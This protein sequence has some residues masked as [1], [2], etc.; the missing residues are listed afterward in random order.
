MFQIVLCTCPN[1]DVANVIAQTLVQEKLAA[2]VNI[3]PKI[4]SVYYWQDKVVCD[5]EIQLLIKTTNEKFALL[6][7]RI[8]SLHTYDVPEIIAVNIQQ[9][10]KQYLN[11]ITE[12]IK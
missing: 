12:S 9:G 10:D 11:W 6:A 7:E 4:T 5:D 1:S 2:C 8:K 3:I